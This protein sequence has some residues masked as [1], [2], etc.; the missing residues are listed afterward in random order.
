MEDTRQFF[1]CEQCAVEYNIQTD[2]EVDPGFIPFCGEP[3]DILEW[4][5]KENTI[6][7]SEGS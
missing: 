1:E 6:E 2:M 4:T 7:E 3:L 5:D